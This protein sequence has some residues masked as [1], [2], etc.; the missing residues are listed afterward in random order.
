MT[1]AFQF[2]YHNK[3]EAGDI[4]GVMVCQI[5]ADSYKEAHTKAVE[6]IKTVEGGEEAT[7]R[8]VKKLPQK[9]AAKKTD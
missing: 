8:T 3:N 5:K 9:K 2:M 4:E 7:A 6:H 1:K